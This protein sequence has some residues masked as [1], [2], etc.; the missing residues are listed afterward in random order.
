M[1]VSIATSTRPPHAAAALRSIGST[2][3][4]QKFSGGSVDSRARS[5]ARALA[6]QQVPVAG[7]Q[8]EPA[9]P[10]RLAVRAPRRRAARPTA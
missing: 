4:R 9:G 10:Q 2:E 6:D 5:A 3:G 8:I 7:R 1:P